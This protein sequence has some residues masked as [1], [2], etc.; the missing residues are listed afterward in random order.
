[1]EFPILTLVLAIH[2][3]K[4]YINLELYVCTHLAFGHDNGAQHAAEGC[5]ATAR[6]PDPRNQFHPSY[7]TVVVPMPHRQI[8]GRI[9]PLIEVHERQKRGYNCLDYEYYCFKHCQGF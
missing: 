5:S 1:M 3:L 8:R 4:H 2:A 6:H 9:Y 7:V